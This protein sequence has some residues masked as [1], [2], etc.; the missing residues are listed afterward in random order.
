MPQAPQLVLQDQVPADFTFDPR[1]ASFK[2][3]RWES[4]DSD[5]FMGRPS[6]KLN[7][8]LNKGETH[9]FAEIRLVLPVEITDTDTGTVSIQDTCRAYLR[10]TC[11]TGVADEHNERLYTLVTALLTNSGIANAV[12]DGDTFF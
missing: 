4:L 9:R 11:P 1:G 12:I 3:S 5:T 10:F 7:S 6:I 2:E 8:S